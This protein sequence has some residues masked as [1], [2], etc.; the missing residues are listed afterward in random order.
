MTKRETLNISPA[1]DALIGIAREVLKTAWPH[2]KAGKSM[3]RILRECGVDVPEPDDP[4]PGDLKT[5]VI[6]WEEHTSHAAVVTVPHDFDLDSGQPWG[7]ADAVGN[8]NDDTY[9]TMI[10]KHNFIVREERI[11]DPRVEELSFIEWH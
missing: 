5:V 7:I 11:H 3:R 9:E 1:V 8:I 2:S 6:E 4:K 10:G